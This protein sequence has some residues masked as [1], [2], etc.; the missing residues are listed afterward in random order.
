[1]GKDEGEVG[2]TESNTNC[3]Y[4]SDSR[5]G[6]GKQGRGDRSSIKYHLGRQGRMRESDSYRIEYHLHVLECDNRIEKGEEVIETAL[7]TT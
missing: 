2:E 5:I 7:N 6:K 3:M 4:L 1:M